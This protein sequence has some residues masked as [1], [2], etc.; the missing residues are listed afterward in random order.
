MFDQSEIQMLFCDKGVSSVDFYR[1]IGARPDTT[2]AE[3][4]Q[5][6]RTHL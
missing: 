4:I 5:T 6:E 1:E 2:V 3:L